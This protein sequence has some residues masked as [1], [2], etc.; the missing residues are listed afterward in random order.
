MEDNRKQIFD[1]ITRIFSKYTPPLTVVS[2]FDS[3]YELVSK[4]EVEI[5]GRKFKELY[6]GAAII[7]KNYVGFYMMTIYMHTELIE[8]IPENLKKCLK[9]KSCF[10][11]KKWDAQMKKDIEKTVKDGFDCYKKLKYV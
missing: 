3:R 2:K 5:A 1:E 10:H 7:Q 9:G 4:K 11:I 6:F 8:K